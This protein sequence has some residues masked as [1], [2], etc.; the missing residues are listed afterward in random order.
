MKLLII[1]LITFLAKKGFIE[2]PDLKWFS[3][4]KDKDDN[5]KSK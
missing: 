2:I 1:A 3:K 4:N 5:L